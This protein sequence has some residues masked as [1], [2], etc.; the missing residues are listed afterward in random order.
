LPVA[1]QSAIKEIE[2]LKEEIKQQELLEER[3]AKLEALLLNE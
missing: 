1:L 3:L 2:N